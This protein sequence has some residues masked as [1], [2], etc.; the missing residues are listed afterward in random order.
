MRPQSRRSSRW[1]GGRSRTQNAATPATI[2][3]IWPAWPGMRKFSYA[4]PE[5]IANATTP[6]ATPTPTR[7]RAMTNSSTPSAICSA[8]SGAIMS[9]NA[10]SPP[11]FSSTMKSAMMSTDRCSLWGSSSDGAPSPRRSVTTIHSSRLNVSPRE[12]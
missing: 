5:S 11:S 2:D 6:T 1:D 8:M 3:A 10:S 7:A 4:S 9:G 12:R